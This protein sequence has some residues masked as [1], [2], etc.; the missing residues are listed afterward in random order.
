ML[1]EIPKVTETHI[2]TSILAFI[3]LVPSVGD[4]VGEQLADAHFSLVA[5]VVGTLEK[6]R[7]LFCYCLGELISYEFS[8]LRHEIRKCLFFEHMG[9]KI[10]PW[11][12]LNEPIWF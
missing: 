11:Y 4:Y 9:H 7:L 1:S 8:C 6:A 3:R 2:T 10:L 12:A 5:P